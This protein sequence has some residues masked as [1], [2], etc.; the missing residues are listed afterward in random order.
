[1]SYHRFGLRTR[2]L[3][4][5]HPCHTYRANTPNDQ[6]YEELFVS[7]SYNRTYQAMS[8]RDYMPCLSPNIYAKRASRLPVAF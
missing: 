2:V 5:C 3:L 8:F 1:M 6:F 4:D 7:L